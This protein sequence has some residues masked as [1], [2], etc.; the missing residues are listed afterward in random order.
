MLMEFLGLMKLVGELALE[1]MRM[2][3]RNFGIILKVVY[4][5]YLYLSKY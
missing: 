2:R 1:I 4:K 5:N 3:V